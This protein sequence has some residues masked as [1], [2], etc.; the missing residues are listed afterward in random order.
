MTHIC[1]SKLTI[2]GWDNGFGAWPVLSHYLNQCRNIVSWTP[3]NKIKWNI[4]QIYT[5]SS[6]NTFE[7]GKWPWQCTTTCLDNSTEL[8]MEKIHQASSG[9]RDMGSASLAATCLPAC[10]PARQPEPWQQYPSSPKGW[11]VK[12]VFPVKHDHL[13]FIMGIPILVKHNLYI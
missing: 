8:Q 11:G 5:F 9:C 3:G 2:I 4:N 10:L 7:M 12:T 1:F 6:K 13:F